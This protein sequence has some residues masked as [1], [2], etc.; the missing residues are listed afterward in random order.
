MIEHLPESITRQTPGVSCTTTLTHEPQR[1]EISQSENRQIS[2]SEVRTVRQIGESLDFNGEVLTVNPLNDSRWNDLVETHPNSS[3]FH[4]VGW[5]EA[6]RRTYGYE[7]CVVSID[8]KNK[9][10]SNGLVFCVVQSWL[11]GPRLVALPFSDHCDPLVNDPQEL[12]AL[13]GLLEAQVRK[14]R[15]AY[16]EIRPSAQSHSIASQ[17]LLPQDEAF[18]IH[19]L[20]MHASLDVLY[21]RFHKSCVQRKIRKAEKQRLQYEEVRSEELLAKFYS[22]FVQTRRRHRLPP[23]PLKWFRNLCLC[24][25]DRLKIRLVS[26]DNRPLAGMITTI[27]RD[28]AVYKYGCSDSRYHNLGTMSLLMWRAIQ[29]AKMSGA[30]RFDLGRSNNANKGLIAFKEHWGAAKN[31]LHYYRYPAGIKT[32]ASSSWK[33]WLVKQTCSH[34]PDPF[35]VALGEALYK[36]IG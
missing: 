28:T 11:S 27:F 18:C 29:D 30:C 33:A 13:V 32:D 25:G 7:P 6:L 16:L 35:L 22:L 12:E 36:H 23:Q 10:L 31:S 1:R 20:D 8:S 4:T 5:L 19:Q 3:I 9:P 17:S 26:K 2:V 15:Y 34:L 24:L 14:S 21:S